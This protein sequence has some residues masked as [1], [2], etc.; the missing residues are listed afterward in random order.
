MRKAIFCV[1]FI[2]SLAVT[3]MTL[4]YATYIDVILSFGSLIF[5]WMLLFIL[6][7]ISIFIKSITVPLLVSCAYLYRLLSVGDFYAG[8]IVSAGAVFVILYVVCLVFSFFYKRMSSTALPS[9]R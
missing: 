8:E 7:N 5:G 6:K 9:L 2:I 3:Y 4:F 1:S